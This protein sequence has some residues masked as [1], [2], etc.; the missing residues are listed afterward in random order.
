MRYCDNCG[1]IAG[2]R[3]KF[4]D[5]RRDSDDQDAYVER[6][7]C[8]TSCEQD[9]IDDLEKKAQVARLVN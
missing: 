4:R 1:G 2:E 7:F 5:P 6:Y 8:S 9:I 3:R